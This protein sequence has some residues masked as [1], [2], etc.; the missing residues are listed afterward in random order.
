MLFLLF[1]LTGCLHRSSLPSDAGKAPGEVQQQVRGWR[2]LEKQLGGVKHAGT[3]QSMRGSLFVEKAVNLPHF[4]VSMPLAN[5]PQPYNQLVTS[6]FNLETQ[7]HS[8]P[9][10]SAINNRIKAACL[11]AC[12][13]GSIYW[14][15]LVWVK[16]EL[17]CDMCVKSSETGAVVS[18]VQLQTLG[19]PKMCLFCFC[20]V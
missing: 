11:P 2:D 20:F 8:E 5:K 15:C 17:S 18:T 12:L 14:Q 4:I 13:L 10:S 9:Q 3:E 19:M 6:H 7:Y 16:A 1:C